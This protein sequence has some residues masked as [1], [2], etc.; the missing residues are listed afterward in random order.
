M[1][2]QGGQG[3]VTTVYVVMKLFNQAAG[4]WDVASLLCWTRKSTKSRHPSLCARSAPKCPL[5]L[6]EQHEY[7]VPLTTI[8]PALE[9]GG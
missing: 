5:N 6:R 7:I 1:I 3:R 4:N 9:Q 2:A 8:N